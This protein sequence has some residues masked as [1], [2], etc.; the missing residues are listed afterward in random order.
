MVKHK[1]VLASPEGVEWFNREH[2]DPFSL[3][4]LGDERD[5]DLNVDQKRALLAAGWLEESEPKKEKK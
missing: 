1:Y 4:E 5:V 2:G 3:A